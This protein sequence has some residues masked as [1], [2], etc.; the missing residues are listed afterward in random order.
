MEAQIEIEWRRMQD[1]P[2]QIVLWSVAGSKH[3]PQRSNIPLPCTFKSPCG[4][5]NDR[6][7]LIDPGVVLSAIE[8]RQ[9]EASLMHPRSHS[10]VLAHTQ[11]NQF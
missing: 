9:V 6:E 2:E 7:H 8:E 3:A 5:S 4:V 10:Q 11:G 1:K